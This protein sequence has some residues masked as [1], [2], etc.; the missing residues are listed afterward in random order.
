MPVRNSSSTS[1]MRKFRWL[2]SVVFWS[3][4]LECVLCLKLYCVSDRSDKY[5]CNTWLLFVNMYICSICVIARGCLTDPSC[6]DAFEIDSTCYKIHKEQVNWFI[7]VNRCL[8]NNASLAV[9]DDNV[10]QYFPSS[11]LSNRTWIGLVKSW[12]TWPGLGQTKLD[13]NDVCD[14]ICRGFKTFTCLT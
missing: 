7:A 5:S 9:F 11:L 3:S 2:S 14:G 4:S 12:W 13:D 6:E 8:S 10:R 1:T